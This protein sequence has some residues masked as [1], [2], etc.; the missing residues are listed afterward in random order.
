MGD[1]GMNTAATLS[2]IIKDD[3]ICDP[4]P[5]KPQSYKCPKCDKVFKTKSNLNHHVRAVHDQIKNHKCT[6]CNASYY[7]KADLVN[8]QRSHQG[9]KPFACTVKG[10]K[11]RFTTKSNRTKH[12]KRMHGDGCQSIT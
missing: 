9:V 11:A 5:F 3:M 2:G 12:I 1:N 7:K 4:V 10:C 8:H 6:Q